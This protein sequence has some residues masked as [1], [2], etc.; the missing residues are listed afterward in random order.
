MRGS[1]KRDH[2]NPQKALDVGETSSLLP[3][4]QGR[5]LC[6]DTSYYANPLIM[7]QLN[8][9][10]VMRRCYKSKSV[11]VGSTVCHP[12]GIMRHQV[13]IQPSCGEMVDVE[14]GVNHVGSLDNVYDGEGGAGRVDPVSCKYIPSPPHTPLPSSNNLMHPQWSDLSNSLNQAYREFVTKYTGIVLTYVVC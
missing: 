3:A 4:T 13:S 6:N 1:S 10:D 8:I 7:C 12:V 11:E 2:T 14:Q 9:K 5:P